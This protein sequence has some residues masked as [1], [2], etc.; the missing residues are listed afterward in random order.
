METIPTIEVKRKLD[1]LKVIINEEDYD[2]ALHEPEDAPK[3]EETDG[4]QDDSEVKDTTEVKT[5]Q[6]IS[7]RDAILSLD[8]AN[9]DH[10]TASGQP[11]MEAVEATFGINVTRKDVDAVAWDINRD[12]IKGDASG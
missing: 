3:V 2:P 11:K 10:W 8:P 12:T 7:L 4:T 6:H 5:T 1:G 9:D